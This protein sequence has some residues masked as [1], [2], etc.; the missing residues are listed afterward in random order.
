MRPHPISSA[1][2]K[3]LS[4]F[5]LVQPGMAESATRFSWCFLLLGWLV[6]S[7]AAA[8]VASSNDVVVLEEI[9]GD[10]LTSAAP[11][12]RLP[13]GSAA[14]TDEQHPLGGQAARTALPPPTQRDSHRSAATDRSWWTPVAS[15]ALVLAMIVLGARIYRFYAAPARQDLPSE[16]L[17]VL[18]SAQLEPKLTLH[19][20]RWGP[21]LLLIGSGP[22]GLQSL[23][24]LSDA[25]EVE[26][27]AAACRAKRPRSAT[28]TLRRVWNP[29]QGMGLL[30]RLELRR[31]GHS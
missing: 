25:D 12:N 18:G 17:Q 7:T 27:V 3:F 31:E 1:T 30:R 8:Q 15:L 23:A 19:V 20:V 24:E 26:R 13:D 29:A 6:G 4:A 28:T 5:E 21:R 11:A 22:Q 10:A 16:A 2:A 14:P 9:S